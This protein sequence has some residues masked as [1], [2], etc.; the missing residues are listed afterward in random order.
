MKK[1][2]KVILFAFLLV[3]GVL[4]QVQLY[5][6][7]P[8]KRPD[9]SGSVVAFIGGF[10]SLAAEIVWFRADRLQEEGRYVE[11]S[12][13]ASTL[14]FLEPHTPEVW[15]FAA[16]N[17]AYNISVMMPTYEDRWRWVEAGLKLLRDD[18][19]RMNPEEAELYRELAWMFQIKL[20]GDIDSASALYRRKWKEKVESVAGDWSKLAMSRR[21]MEDVEKATSF[22]DWTDPRLSAVYWAK[23]GLPFAQGNTKKFL[24]EIIRQSLY[25]MRND[26]AKFSL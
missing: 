10:R 14:T 5:R 20:G 11:L 26:K 25:A 18:A 6:M 16:W 23:K 2:V 17:L 19:I 4:L 1:N 8:F 3:A 22:S 24:V 13:L 15:S 7:R 12:Q 21:E 9:I